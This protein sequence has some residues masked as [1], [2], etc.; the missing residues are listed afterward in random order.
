MKRGTMKNRYENL[1]TVL[2]KL[3]KLFREHNVEY[4]IVGS[5]SLFLHGINVEPSDIDILTTKDSAFKIDKLLDDYKVLPCKFRESSI[6]RSYF[7]RYRVNEI[8]V[9]IMG[10]LQ[11]KKE[12]KWSNPITPHTIRTKWININGEKIKVAVLEETYNF[13]RE[14]GREETCKLIESYFK[15]KGINVKF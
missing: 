2:K 8:N 12:N 9:E 1:I 13:C 11:Y 15:E 7:G 10:E 4:C 3:A 14:V 6:F 5:T